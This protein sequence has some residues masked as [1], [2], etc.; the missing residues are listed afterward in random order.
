MHSPRWSIFYDFHTQ[1][2]QPDV[3]E[4][5]DA[6][7]F[8]GR[9]RECGVDFIVF[10]AR[11]NLGMAYYNTKVGIR[12]P[13]LKY[14]LIGRMVEACRRNGIAMS[15]YF[16][17]GLSHEEGLLHRDWLKVQP[18]GHVYAPDRMDHFFR[19]MCYNTGYAEHLLE[20]IREVVQGY[21]V[22]GLFLDCMNNV[23]CVGV[24][25]IRE[26]K[27]RGVDWQDA[28]QV[29]EF[30]RQ[31]KVRMAQRIRDAA[32]ALRPDLML[33][34]NGVSAEEQAGIGTY[35][36]YECLPTGGWG[37]EVLPVYSRYLRNLGKQ[38]LNMT[39]RFHRSWGDFGGIRSQAGLEYDCVYGLANGLRPTVG[40][41]YHP[42]GDINPAVFDL[43]RGIYGR[44]QK[45]EPWI[46]GAVPAVDAAVVATGPE[47][48]GGAVIG[49]TRMLCELKAQF[50]VL[51]PAARWRDY[52][53]LVLPDTV[54][55]SKPLTARVREHLD[56]G[57]A[58]IASHRSGLDPARQGFVLPDWGV[59]YLGE[60]PA[61]NDKWDKVPGGSFALPEP[62]YFVA[63]GPTAAGLPEMPVNC[64]ERGTVV[65]ALP[66]SEVLAQMVSSYFPRHWD[67][68][69]HHLY[70]APDRV[71]D[72][73]MVTRSGNV[74]Y[75]SHPWFT[76]YHRYA[77]LPLR[78][79]VGNLMRDL[80]PEPLVQVAGLPSF[81]RAMVTEQPKRRM[82]W[83]T[84]YVPERR[85]PAIDMIEEP[86]VLRDV[87]VRL[88]LDGK[89]L[90]R[91][92]L[93]PSGTELACTIA[94][95]YATVRVPEV[96]GYAVVV[97]EE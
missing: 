3:G 96:R 92:Y 73:P 74:A 33:Y 91:A 67:G 26:M 13:S 16:N 12:H 58:V 89:A 49:A 57:G 40:D 87:E 94:G 71:T 50:D 4:T 51:T 56:R 83:L 62:A 30:A 41:H 27:Q 80:L 77:P 34:F 15:V 11:C 8:T 84:A 44:L 61:V 7:E 38:V 59:R 45:L 22:A 1:V 60:D 54:A 29:A 70:I 53:L 72:R 9:L 48:L 81:G 39:G 36:E 24:E 21:P 82:V 52:R 31:S 68:E 14:D 17:V 6:G 88:R 19:L 93:A 65:E 55:L 25:C 43:I 64:Y 85:G 37:Y 75:I 79:A 86:I 35:L 69:H 5:F 66:G 97:F 78:V 23:P 32:L 47:A 63:E 95:G 42:R 10:H 2:A 46:A 76:S 18:E 28:G 90:Q 20:M